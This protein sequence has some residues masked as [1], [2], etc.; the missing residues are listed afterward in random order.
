MLRLKL[1]LAIRNLLKNKLYS[2][3]IIGGFAIGFTACILIAL[4]YS[5][6]Y[7]VDK[8]FANYKN[9]YR[10]YDVQKNENVLDYK[11]NSVLSENY[12]DV[13]E[14]C[15]MNYLPNFTM[16]LKDPETKKYTQ[17]SHSI[18]TSNSF[19]DIFSVEIVASQSDK[20]FAGSNSAV[21]SESVAERLF[22]DNNPLGQT[23]E[24][25]SLVVTVT[26]IIK[27]LPENSSFKAEFLLNIE[28]KDYQIPRGTINGVPIY[29]TEHFLLLENDVVPVRFAA[30]LNSTIDQYNSTT[31]SLALQNLSD[32]LFIHTSVKPR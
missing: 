14:T 10:L 19:F 16:T 20:P 5:V 3:L 21:I 2:S 17:V 28:N 27:D 11:L 12:P 4:F 31:D 9:I 1:K 32:N 6:E 7:N 24:E 26:A 15:A 8:H 18:Y 25:G 13:K 29:S 30:N 22:G 23:I